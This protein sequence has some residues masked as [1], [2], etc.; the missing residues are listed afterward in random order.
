MNTG[1]VT[2]GSVNIDTGG[3]NTNVVPTI[4]VG[5]KATL[6]PTPAFAMSDTLASVT[7]SA[8]A[9]A[10]IG[11]AGT[12]E[13]HI[14]AVPIANADDTAVSNEVAEPAA[15]AGER[16][17]PD[18]ANRTCDKP[19]SASAARVLTT[20]TSEKPNWSTTIFKSTPGSASAYVATLPDSVGFGNTTPGHDHV[21]TWPCDTSVARK[22]VP[23]PD[24]VTGIGDA[25]GETVPSGFTFNV[26][27]TGAHEPLAAFACTGSAYTVAVKEPSTLATTVDVDD[28]NPLTIT[29]RPH[30]AAKADADASSGRDIE[31]AQAAWAG[32]GTTDMSAVTTALQAAPTKMRRN[33]NLRADPFNNRRD[34]ARRDWAPALDNDERIVA[35]AARILRALNLRIDMTAGP[36]DASLIWASF[37][38]ALAGTVGGRPPQNHL[39]R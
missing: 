9:P 1:N 3:V 35:A 6:A 10:T 24:N 38:V 30:D 17:V 5:T 7:S 16:P 26:V 32:A 33:A 19:G 22:A 12:V 23:P 27:E 11:V 2:D 13:S 34:R 20:S 8:G 36:G 39:I 28:S 37:D 25:T 29:D 4:A 31:D 14:R 15:A 21:N 18:S